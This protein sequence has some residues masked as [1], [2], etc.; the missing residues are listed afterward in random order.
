ME[1]IL[2]GGCNFDFREFGALISFNPYRSIASFESIKNRV[3]G[4][5]MLLDIGANRFA[6]SPK[7]L[8]DNYAALDVQFVELVMFEPDMKGME[9]I[10]EIY[11]S[12]MNLTFHQQYVEVG[13]RNADNDVV[14]WI[15]THVAQE[16]FFV[17]KFYVDEGVRVP[18]M[19]WSIL[20]DLLHSDALSLVD[21]LYNEL[22][23]KSKTV[24][25][26]HPTHSC[27]QHYDIVRQLRSCGM[28]IHDW[29]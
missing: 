28:A 29:P 25:W 5:K 15:K 3:Y 1:P 27:R 10:P 26:K 6:T 14:S 11:R 8:M 17:L 2:P 24:P 12:K 16:N 20:A 21:D 22:H 19:E 18:T 9:Y 23:F 7:Q 13:S 4:K